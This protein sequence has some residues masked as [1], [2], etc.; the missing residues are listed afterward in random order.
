MGKQV[1]LAVAG[2]GKTY[3]LCHNLNKDKRNLIL[4]FTNQ[5]IFNIKRELIDAYGVV[6]AYTKVMTFHSFIYQFFI[7][8]YEPTILNFF[9]IYRFQHEGVSFRKPPEPTFI[10]NG[11][12]LPNKGYHKKDEFEHYVF[13][14]KYYCGL[15][16]ELILYI[17]NKDV[18]LIKRGSQNLMKFFDN[19][20]VDEFQDFR[21]YDYELLTNMS[22]YVNNIMLLG[23][24]Y[25]HSVSGKNNS[26]KPF[27]KGKNNI[28]YIEYLNELENNEFSIDVETLNAS[29]RCPKEI[30]DFI[31][32]RLGIN[33]DANNSNKGRVIFVR[34][35]EIENIITNDSIKKLV[36][37]EAEKY[38]FN[39]INWGYSKGDTYSNVCVILTD[40]FEN[41]DEED[42]QIEDKTTTI[43]KLYVALSRTRG[44]LYIIKKSEFDLVKHKYLCNK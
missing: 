29:R 21:E 7:C 18:N 1:V 40:T 13:M 14:K 2:S 31:T 17:K 35:D 15:M 12:R 41:I 8:T 30:C 3:T 38:S 20:Y 10:R 39:S 16:S 37:M 32:K 4:A 42:F 23:D 19:I 44:N 11:R 25:Q 6:P 34:Q 33:I 22:R 43:N 5:N 24:F 26:G 27:K 9:D 36:Y 28:T